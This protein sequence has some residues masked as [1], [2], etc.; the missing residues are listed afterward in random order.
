MPNPAPKPVHAE[1]YAAARVED[2]L[3]LKIFLGKSPV[4][5]AT[6]RVGLVH[7]DLEKL[8]HL[9]ITGATGGGKSTLMASTAWQ[10]ANQ[11][12]PR[13]E[14]PRDCQRATLTIALLVRVAAHLGSANG[15]SAI[16]YHQLPGGAETTPRWGGQAYFI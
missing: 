14:L 10:V 9:A 5:L 4:D 11:N 1:R 2:Q 16:R 3:N 7:L 12:D 8:P 15:S 13:D 6:L